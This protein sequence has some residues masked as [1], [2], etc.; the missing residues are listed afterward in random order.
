MAT[1]TRRDERAFGL[2]MGM[3]CGLFAG[4]AAWR[5]AVIASAL[6]GGIS[7]V[8]IGLALVRPSLL[9]MPSAV[10][11]RVTSAIGWVVS[12]ACLSATFFL[13]VT[14]VGLVLRLFGRDPLRLRPA[15]RGGSGWV[16]YPARVRDPR[17]YERMY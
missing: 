10:W 4:H 7:L 6:L 16:P 15:A 13:I 1:S 3:V 5:G 11:E 9:R 8:L 2:S 12:R 17:H 14:P